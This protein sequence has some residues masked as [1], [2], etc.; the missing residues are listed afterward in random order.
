M[1]LTVYTVVALLAALFTV[2]ATR[3]MSGWVRSAVVILAAVCALPITPFVRSISTSPNELVYLALAT[4]A[5]PALGIVAVLVA[6]AVRRGTTRTSADRSAPSTALRLAHGALA[7]VVVAAFAGGG[8]AALSALW[9]SRIPLRYGGPKP[10]AEF[11]QWSAIKTSVEHTVTVTLDVWLVIGVVVAC[12]V[13][14]LVSS[15]RATARRSMALTLVAVSAVVLS[16]VSLVSFLQIVLPSIAPSYPIGLG[17]EVAEIGLV[18]LLLVLASG[19]RTIVSI[20][21]GPD[22]TSDLLDRARG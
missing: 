14:L 13:A 15:R 22:I 18:V 7:A 6:M 16:F 1:L 3:G 19:K 11:D 9:D 21:P 10:S 4:I 12:A 2:L 17:T 5:L 20:V 8:F